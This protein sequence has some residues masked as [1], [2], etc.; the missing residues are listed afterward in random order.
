[1][2]IVVTGGCG[3]LGHHLVEILPDKNY[4]TVIDFKRPTMPV[5]DV[6][7][8]CGNI[9]DTEIVKN[10]MNHAD[11]VFHL[12]AF[13][14]V[15]ESFS[16]PLLYVKNNIL[17]TTNL[18]KNCNCPFVFISS[19]S[20]YGNSDNLPLKEEE[21]TN[22]LSPY[23]VSKVAGEHLTKIFAKD[24]GF[25]FTIVR[26]F[27]IY[28]HRQKSGVIHSFLKRRIENK[29]MIVYGDGKQTRDFINVSDV[30]EFLSRMINKFPDGETFNVGSGKET[31]I[32]ELCEMISGDISYIESN[33]EG[34]RR[35]VADISRAKRVL[36][37]KPKI[38]LK[39]GIKELIK[40]Y[41][42]YS[43]SG[44]SLQ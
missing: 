33:N 43:S 10:L 4:I 36:G 3:F 15:K 7:Y 9:L 18:L 30:A 6:H 22:P 16:N 27:N 31:S 11:L 37:W 28:G 12:A 19:A 34:V 24:R 2:K 44:S 42:K 26:P 32:K 38:T 39:D 20:V 13:L 21:P 5:K 23:A 29:P 17:G 1:M 35:S 41:G 25:L 8:I 14:D 40:T